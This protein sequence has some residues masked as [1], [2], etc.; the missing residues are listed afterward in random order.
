[1]AL[2]SRRRLLVAGATTAAS[3]A[4]VSGGYTL[5]HSERARAAETSGAE[6]FWGRHQAGIT[7]AQ[8]DRL[9]FAAF[10]LTTTDV[11]AVRT[12]LRKWTAAA[13]TMTAGQMV[14][15][16]Q[17]SDLAPPTDTGEAD[18]LDPAHLTI[19]F[20]F[21]AS[22]FGNNGTDRF[23]LASRR[24]APLIDMP[25]FAGDEID[26]AVSDGDLCVQACSNDPLVA[27]HAVRNLARIARGTAQLRWSQQGFGRTSSTTPDQVTPRNLM[28]FKDGTNNLADTQAAHDAHLWVGRDDDPAWM[29]DGSY[30]VV[31]RIRIHIEVWDRS[32]L[33][34]QEATVGRLKASGAPIGSRNEHDSIDLAAKGADGELLIPARAHARVA[35]QIGND[36]HILRRGY[37]FTDGIDEQ[38]G[39][40]DAGLFFLAYQ[41]DP[42]TQFVPLQ[43]QLA[44]H[45]ALNEY[46]QHVSSAMFAIPPGAAEGS[47]IGATLF[48]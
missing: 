40:L 7:T 38:T 39:Q 1:M 34:D 33:A 21:G 17:T 8:Q 41:R 46:I 37:S 22:L 30:L 13:A 43:A 27:Y 18:G 44:T 29:A 26:P 35:N 28:G 45:D 20:G 14:G 15:P 9:H 12:L 48:G 23:G 19:T 25:A 5:G 36:I 4:V 31:R 3:A 2:L 16:A 32:S 6:A 42:R 24:P 10:D 11:D 47:Y